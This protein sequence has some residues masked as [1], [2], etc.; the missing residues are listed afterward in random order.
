M[1]DTFGHHTDPDGYGSSVFGFWGQR[2]GLRRL[3][4]SPLLAGS[5]LTSP[6]WL[7]FAAFLG[8]TFFLARGKHPADLALLV[9]A[10]AIGAT[11]VK[12][13][14]TGTYLAWSYPLLLLGFFTNG[15][16]R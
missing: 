6:M 8:A 4:S 9:G 5:G 12:P 15:G 14:A 2:E 10:V 13:H 3:L 1:Y 16:E 7:T 11:L